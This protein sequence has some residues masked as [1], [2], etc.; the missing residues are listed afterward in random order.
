MRKGLKLDRF[1][2]NREHLTSVMVNFYQ[3]DRDG[4]T[5]YG[6]MSS[7]DHPSFD[8]LRNHLGH[9]GY[10]ELRSRWNQDTALKDFILNGHIFY[11]GDRFPCA[12]A[13]GIQF[14]CAD[15]QQ[16]SNE[17]DEDLFYV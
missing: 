1:K 7:I 10:I 4:A 15:K 12:S 16:T 13:L 9:C 6:T 14:K 3:V 5:I 11:E 8:A 17:L 2:I